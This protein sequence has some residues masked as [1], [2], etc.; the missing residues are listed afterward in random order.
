MWTQLHFGTQ[1]SADVPS[2]V[3][4][5]LKYMVG[6]CGDE[7]PLPVHPLFSKSRWKRMLRC[8]SYYFHYKTTSLL[9]FDD[10]A[11]QWYFNITCNLKNYGEIEAFVDWIMPYCGESAGAF[12]GYSRYV[13]AEI[14]TMI[15][16]GDT[17]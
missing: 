16:M 12:L 10:I 15:F 2:D 11:Q 5:V 13:E 9:R 3:I 14:P 7:P 1:L 8:D 17:A 6:G 4:E